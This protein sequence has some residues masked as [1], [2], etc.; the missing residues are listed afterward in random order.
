MSRKL[1]ERLVI[2]RGF[3]ELEVHWAAKDLGYSF[4]DEV[5]DEN[6][7][8]SAAKE[9]ELKSYQRRADRNKEP[10]LHK[11]NPRSTLTGTGLS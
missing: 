9:V 8:E 2:D 7:F 11:M 3:D 4:W 1:V 10:H 5:R 6:P